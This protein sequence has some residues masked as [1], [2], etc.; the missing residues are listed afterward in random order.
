MNIRHYFAGGNTPFGFYSYYDEVLPP[1]LAQKTI[2]IKGGPGTGKSTLMKSLG[3]HWAKQGYLVEFLHCSGD[4]G[5]LDGVVC[6]EEGWSVLDATAPHAQDPKLLGAVDLIFDPGRFVDTSA[7]IPHRERLSELTAAK[8]RAYARAYRYL[9]MAGTLF[10]GILE[11]QQKAMV[12]HADIQTAEAFFN[13]FLADLPITERRGRLRH[14][15]A[16][17]ITP[18]G[19]MGYEDTLFE[20][21]EI[22]VLRTENGIGA[23]AVLKR[24]AESALARGISVQA[25]CSPMLPDR[26]EHLVLEELRLAVTTAEKVS[27]VKTVELLDFV[28]LEQ[29]NREISRDLQLFGYLLDRTVEALRAAREEHARLE[30]ILVPSMDFERM[31]DEFSQILS[32]YRLS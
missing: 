12:P 21:N 13:T 11:Q 14:A 10:S 2:Y 20:E 31:Q 19:V 15:F 7:V 30:E 17:A 16:G 22:Y 23:D 1:A 27:A 4:P 5:S 24:I 8:K 9:A 28:K 25:Y 3:V 29:I 26:I 32:Q 6:R 18:V